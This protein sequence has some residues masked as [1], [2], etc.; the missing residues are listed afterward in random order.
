MDRFKNIILILAVIAVAIVWRIPKLDL[1][2]MH[3]DEAVNAIKLGQLWLKG[4]YKYDPDEYHGPTLHYFTLPFV[5]ASGAK[6]FVQL[7]EKTMRS[8]IVFFALVSILLIW[9]LRDLLGKSGVFF[10]MLFAS[11]S[12]MSVFYSRYFIHEMLLV[13]FTTMFMVGGIRYLKNPKLGWALLAGVGAGLMYA[14]KET[15]ILA[16][17]AIF[18]AVF[19]ELIWRYYV[20]K[21]EESPKCDC[22]VVKTF[23]WLSPLSNRVKMSHIVIGIVTCLI[24]SIL[25]F[26]SFFKNPAGII[27]SV[28][29]YLP[30]LERAGGKSPHIH[31]WYFYFERIL[32]F[33]PPRSHLW[34]EGAILIFALI[35]CWFAFN[36]KNGTNKGT[37]RFFII[38]TVTLA[39]IY[40][41]ISYKT[42]WCALGFWFGAIVVAGYG[43]GKLFESASVAWQKA[44][45]IVLII[46]GMAQLCW[47]S[48]RGNFVWFADRRNPYVYSQTSPDILRLVETVKGLSKIHPEGRKLVI[49]VASPEHDYWPL[50]WY[51]REFENV[52]WYDKLP[53]E[54]L[55][56]II[57]AN[58]LAGV[59]VDEKT[60]KEWLMVGLF[61]MRP[62]VFFELFVEFKWWEKYV[63]SMPR[64]K[65]E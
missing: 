6:D 15:F 30:W 14:T 11:V 54:P 42:P 32:W 48:W 20:E 7:S 40:S 53:N 24:I 2:P 64:P 41:A 58:S 35:G 47:M 33:K 29:T 57:I 60:N 62:R 13:C 21:Q 26:T 3:N 16:F 9:L 4:E 31:P 28:K 22:V 49:K 65:D 23:P 51:L 38:Y 44:I 27:D 43:A 17:F 63:M 19:F 46:T 45:V 5:V 12:P 52:G 18:V 25:F 50:P 34:T 56:P 39:A 8:T 10:A 36:K 59:D 61:E 1:R 55:P 37:A